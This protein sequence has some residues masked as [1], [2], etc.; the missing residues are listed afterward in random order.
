MEKKRF[1]TEY[2]DNRSKLMAG[3]RIGIID[4]SGAVWIWP[5]LDIDT[6]IRSDAGLGTGYSTGTSYGG[7]DGNGATNRGSNLPDLDIGEDMAQIQA[8]D[9]ILVNARNW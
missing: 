9:R 7:G 1:L 5:Q 4:T 2:T 3:G 6:K 8:N